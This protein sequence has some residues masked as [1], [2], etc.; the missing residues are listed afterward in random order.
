MYEDH[1]TA[2]DHRR[3]ATYIE[4]SAGIQLPDHKRSLIEARLR[5]RQRATGQTSLHAYVNYA[6]DEYPDERV[7][8]IDALTTNKTDFFREVSHFEYLK[9]YISERQQQGGSD[10]AMR[11]WSA[12]C[13]TGEEP[14][15][16]AMVLESLTRTYPDFNYR[17]EATD[18]SVSVLA[19]ARQGIYAH[20]QIGPIPMAYR[21]QYLLRKKD[22]QVDIVKIAAALRQRITFGEFNLLSG[23]YEAMGKFD[24]IFCRNVMIYFNNEIRNKLI[25]NF[26][27]ALK[28]GGLFFIGHS[29]GLSGKTHL[30]TQLVPTVYEKN[31][32]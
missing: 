20:E 10:Q 7:M 8:L 27:R 17:I 4:Q 21:K 1:L 29:E 26:H 13:S 22:H 14:Y 24:V 23:P 19:H 5:K 31:G 2:Q 3:L 15:T 16:L 6:L 32:D 11:F 9:A 12:G 28:P 18:I 25:S 30:F